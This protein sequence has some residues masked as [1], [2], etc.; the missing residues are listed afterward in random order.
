M[1]ESSIVEI[2]LNEE[3]KVINLSVLIPSEQ[4][5]QEEVIQSFYEKQD[6][7]CVQVSEKYSLDD[8]VVN[9]RNVSSE[10]HEQFEVFPLMID[11]CDKKHENLVAMLYEDDQQCIQIAEDRGIEDC[12]S[13][14]SSHVSCF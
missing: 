5:L 13:D 4:S 14:F 9:D 7:I 6:E 11:E 3:N 2:T 1:K 8:Y 12:H 10:F